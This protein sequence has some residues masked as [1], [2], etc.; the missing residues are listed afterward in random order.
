MFGRRWGC[1]AVVDE[2][3]RLIEARRL[4]FVLTGSSARNLRRKGSISLGGRATRF[5]HPLTS[6][7]P[8]RD[9]DL[10]RALRLENNEHR[11]HQRVLVAAARC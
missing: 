1:V 8:G 4:H 5:T 3:H 2:V 7:E 6:M 9:C 10:R 11:L